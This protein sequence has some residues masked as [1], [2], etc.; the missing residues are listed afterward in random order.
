MTPLMR[1]TVKKWEWSAGRFPRP[2]HNKLSMDAQEAPVTLANFYWLSYW[3]LETESVRRLCHSVRALL[4]IC[5]AAYPLVPLR[6]LRVLEFTVHSWS[7][8]KTILENWHSAHSQTAQAIRH[9]CLLPQI[10]PCKRIHE[11]PGFRIPASRFRIP[12]S[13]FWIPTFWIPDSIPKRWI[14]DSSLW[15]PDS[16]SK[17]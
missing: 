14:P 10:A 5:E 13:G 6:K 8:S 16:N 3:N 17:N 2:W 11:G 1:I 12:A 7:G 9:N 4:E 15:I